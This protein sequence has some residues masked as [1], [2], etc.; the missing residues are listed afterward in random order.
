MKPYQPSDK[1]VVRDSLDDEI[2]DDVE[3]DV[4]IRDGRTCKTYE[5]KGLKRPLM[6]AKRK[7][8]SS[9]SAPIMKRRTRC[10]TCCEPF[11]YGLAC[12]TILIALIFLA[13]L[14]LTLFPIP[15]QKVKMMFNKGTMAT[16]KIL[17]KIN[18]NNSEFVPCSQISVNKVW[19]KAIS[20]MSSETPIRKTDVNGD[21]I[22][23]VIIGY[24][25]DESLEY[26]QAPRCTITKTG[27]DGIC[28]G[29]ILALNGATGATL[30]QRWTTLTVFSIYCSVDLNNDQ[31][32]DC[33]AAGRGGLIISVNGKDGD[34]LWELKDVD[35]VGITDILI[36]LYTINPIRDL[37][38]D[39]IS[40]IVAVHVEESSTSKSGHIKIIS[41]G[42][43]KILRTIPTPF[44]EEVFVP[45]QFLIQSDGT[46]AILII[47]GG[48][49]TPGG[50]Y[51]IRTHSLMQFTNEV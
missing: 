3:D 16:T 1:L 32:N 48:Q 46:E 34:V 23:D 8:S 43:G 39:Q 19:S 6:P 14:L 33:V 24:G 18:E 13:A 22:D 38:G 49:N 11:C 51:S 29:G 41:G 2:S 44:G 21:G 36:D 27:E 28:E 30:W 20:K 42:S 5:D 15:L 31:I 25:I 50:L 26:G 10:W 12:L 7:S 9:S 45:L 17:T 47:T 40:D 37:D 35:G 4:F